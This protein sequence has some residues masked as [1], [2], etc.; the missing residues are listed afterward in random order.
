MDAER[1]DAC[2]P[3]PAPAPDACDAVEAER[4]GARPPLRTLLDLSV[5]PLISQTLQACYGLADTLWVARAIG[6]D[7]VAVYGAIFVVEFLALNVA[8]YLMSGLSIRLSYLFGEGRG[9]EA[10]QIYVDFVRVALALAVAVPAVILPATRPLVR[11]FGADERLAAM[12]FAYM[13][14]VSAGCVFNFLYA[15]ACG[16]L[17]AEGRSLLYGAVQFAGVAANLA[18]FDPV[19]LLALR[20]PIWGASLATVL[21]A[22][23]PGVALTWLILAGRFSLRP[24]RRMFVRRF[25]PETLGAL[26]VGFGS[27]AANL[28]FTLPTILMQKWVNE[29]ALA[30]GLYDTIIAVW[31]VIEKV[32]QLVGGITIGFA[33]GLLPAG[34][35]AFGAGRLNRL[36]R[37]FAWAALL[38]GVC[39]TVPGFVVAFLPAQIA[40][41]WD[42]DPVFL[43]W[44]R[45]LIP[46][47]FYTTAFVSLQNTAPALLQGMQ[48]V[49]ASACLSVATFL[50]PLPVFS[51]ILYFTKKGDPERIL[52]AYV[53]NDCFSLLVCAAVL[54]RP[55]RA[56]LRAPKDSE[57]KLAHGRKVREADEEEEEESLRECEAELPAVEAAVDDGPPQL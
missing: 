25:S 15:L 39:S 56:L 49:G 29:A 46:K 13:V 9:A 18:V 17:Q 57:L 54:V 50:L 1:P 32:Y 6:A 48:R 37:L 14:P 28:S 34:A 53:G 44:A 11:W 35:F 40:R 31:A 41:L 36:L 55:L 45:R 38:G 24:A 51:T 52:W 5:G 30:I 27:F 19:L 10:A 2:A 47:A 7:G 8:N 33:Y 20:L 43:E 42:S 21:A 4:L 12:C 22:G 16:L 26:R 23:I 3:A